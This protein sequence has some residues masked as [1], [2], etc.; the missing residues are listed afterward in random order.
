LHHQIFSMK[1]ALYFLFSLL[2]L[3]AC[4]NS[5]IEKKASKIV[6]ETSNTANT[7]LALSV[8]GMVCKMGCGGSIRK[9]LLATNAVEKVDVDFV[10][11]NESQLITVYYN[12]SRSSK[13]KLLKVINEMNDKQFTAQTISESS[14]ISAKK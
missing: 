9:E 14:Y 7:K 11:D 13:A 5:T 12:N 8:Q 10:E 1:T 6:P 3:A 2:F 4:N